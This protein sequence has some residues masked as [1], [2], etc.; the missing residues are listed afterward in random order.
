VYIIKKKL[1]QVYSGHSFE[2]PWWKGVFKAGWGLIHLCG[3][4]AIMTGCSF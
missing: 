1:M 4:G 2:N 3:I